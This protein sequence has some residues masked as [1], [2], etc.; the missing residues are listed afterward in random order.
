MKITDNKC[1]FG[2]GST[3][4]VAIVCEHWVEF[5]FYFKSGNWFRK[6]VGKAGYNGNTDEIVAVAR[7]LLQANYE[8]TKR[9][10]EQMGKEKGA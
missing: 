10:L 7:D 1:E 5:N 9:R 6:F 3:K 8:A 2:L 4:I